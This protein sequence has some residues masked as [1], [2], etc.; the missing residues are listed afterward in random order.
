[1]YLTPD[2]EV[3]PYCDEVKPTPDML[4]ELEATDELILSMFDDDVVPYGVPVILESSGF[5]KEVWVTEVVKVLTFSSSS[6][7]KVFFVLS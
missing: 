5:N 4:L 7:I 6:L 3:D 2:C 1:M